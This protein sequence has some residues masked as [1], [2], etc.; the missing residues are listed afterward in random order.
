VK[1]VT[2]FVLL[3]ALLV[4]VFSLALSP[5]VEASSSYLRPVYVK[6]K[7]I[8]REGWYWL[9]QN[10]HYAR[11]KF[12]KSGWIPS[13]ST[14]VFDLLVADTFRDG[15]YNTTIRVEIFDRHNRLLEQ[16]NVTLRYTGY[17]SHGKYTLTHSY[18]RGLYVVVRWPSLDYKAFAVKRTAIKLYLSSSPPG[19][20]GG[21]NLP[22][23]G[24]GSNLPQPS[25]YLSSFAANGSF[26][27]TTGTGW[28]WLSRTGNYARWVFRYPGS[29]IG[30]LTFTFLVTNPRTFGSGYDTTVRIYIYDRMGFLVEDSYVRLTNHNR[31][32]SYNTFGSG[33]T[34]T[35]RYYM[36][37][38]YRDG[39]TVMVTWP[40]VNG[41]YFA[42]SRGSV[43]FAERTG[44]IIPPSRE[45]RRVVLRPSSFSVR[46]DYIRG[47]YWIR[48]SG[49][50]ARWWFRFSGWRL[51]SG[52]R[53][54]MR[55][56]V[57]N[58]YNGG[59]G[60]STSVKI[61]AYDSYGRYKGSA[62]VRLRNRGG[63]R[64][65]GSYRF[66]KS[67]YSGMYL[68]VKWPSINRYHFAVTRS[69]LSISGWLVK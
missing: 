41:Y 56:L 25:M 24:G 12:Y 26:W 69:S 60:Y 31:R 57:T 14:V 3:S 27:S 6:A 42:V 44:G 35:G 52:A 15:N 29:K 23:S 2:L 54:N 21:Q 16:G 11:W 61:M 65:E 53:L 46:G 64:A 62:Y 36:R 63:Y 20:G 39:F 37:N 8:S 59:S 49:Q 28:Y 5:T 32:H 1:K 33:Y 17:Y 51:L 7:G 10:G 30:M 45:R 55:F 19:G 58:T 47:W 9:T 13:G 43:K 34:A 22:P 50:W 40:S 38:M 66:R 48:R 4:S 18:H 67:Y 68:L